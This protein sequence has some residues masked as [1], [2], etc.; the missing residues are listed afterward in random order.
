VNLTDGKEAFGSTTASFQALR[1]GLGV[2]AV[3]RDQVRAVQQLAVV[4]AAA[5]T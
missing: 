4:T 2:D 1:P 5:H 3:R